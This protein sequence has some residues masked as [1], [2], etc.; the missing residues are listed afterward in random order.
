[1]KDPWMGHLESYGLLELH[2]EA[3][4]VGYR[5][6]VA[7]GWT[8]DLEYEGGLNKYCQCG[9]ALKTFEDTSQGRAEV[10]VLLAEVK[11]D[12]E[13]VKSSS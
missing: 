8:F 4:Q 10:R 13:R 2:N 12:L 11:K 3:Q 1:M 9:F 6:R 7:N 5:I